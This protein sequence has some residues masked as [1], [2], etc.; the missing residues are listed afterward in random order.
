VLDCSLKA[1]NQLRGRI[2]RFL[3]LNG[4]SHNTIL[5]TMT[6]AV[7]VDVNGLDCVTGRSAAFSTE[8]LGVGLIRN[9]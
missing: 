5:D 4:V 2:S 3:A 9:Q 8:L 7:G 1:F 6:Q